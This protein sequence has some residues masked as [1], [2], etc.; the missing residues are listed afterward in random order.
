MP[1]TGNG[2]N[3]VSSIVAVSV[4]RSIEKV[5]ISDFYP[6]TLTDS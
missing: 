1:I 6:R 5:T 4:N 3:I 2:N